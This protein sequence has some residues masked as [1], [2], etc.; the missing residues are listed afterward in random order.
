MRSSAVWVLITSVGFATTVEAQ[1]AIS[2]FP[3]RF[4]FGGDV[5]ISQP[6]SEFAANVKNGYGIDL[7]GMF[8]LDPAGVFNIRADAG[9]IQYG[10]ETKRIPSFV[11][12]RIRYDLETNNRIAFGSIGLQLQAPNGWFRP[13]AN[14]AIAAT[15]FYT[16]S[17]LSSPDDSFE[18]ITNTN[19]SDA[20][21]AWIF[22]GG[23]KI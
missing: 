2:T 15:N 7:T 1:S 17:S 6:K 14:A 10:R 20:S 16:Q 11:S 5:V 23:L 22:G 13:Y 12:G 9:G 4:S 21:S 3:S 18:T 19:Q 8:A